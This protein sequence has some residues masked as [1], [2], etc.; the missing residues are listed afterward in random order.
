[1]IIP[2]INLLLYSYDTASPFHD[3]AR[4]WLEDCLSGTEIVGLPRV[5]LFGFIRVATNSR[6]FQRPMTAVEAGNQVRSWLSQPITQVLDS[7]PLYIREVLKLL[8]TLGTAGNLVTDAQ[9]A[10]AA[11]DHGAVV[12]TSDTDFIRFPG[13][14]WYNPITESGSRSVNKRK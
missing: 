9:I 10:V 4:A 11:L 7:G 13:L 6:A 8:E 3:K 5:V 2:D 12:H 1:M 14:R